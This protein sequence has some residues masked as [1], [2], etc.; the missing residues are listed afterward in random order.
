MSTDPGSAWVEFDAVLMPLAWGRS[1]YTVVELPAHLV[2]QAQQRG[3][4]RLEGVVED[5]LVNVGI[6][7]ADVTPNAFFYVGKPLQRRLDMQPGDLVRCRLRPVDPD[8]VPI[9]NDV[10][11]ALVAADAEAA[12]LAT[13]APRRRQLLV[14]IDAAATAATRAK[15]IEAMLA[16]LR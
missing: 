9:A 8:V 13:P 14:R 15:R 7:R 11:A 3:T 2:R 4:H 1:V 16:Q 12:F 6:A 5:A 10:T